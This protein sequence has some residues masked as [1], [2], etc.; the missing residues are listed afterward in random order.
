MFLNVQG[1][2]FDNG[3]LK[4]IYDIHLI[5]QTFAVEFLK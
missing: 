4:I 3:D 2:K 1:T 5:L